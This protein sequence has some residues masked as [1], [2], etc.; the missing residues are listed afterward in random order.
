MNDATP[1]DTISGRSAGPILAAIMVGSVLL[2]LPAFHWLTGAGDSPDFSFHPDVGQFITGAQDIKAPNPV[3]YPE[4]LVTH[5][6]V[7]HKLLAPLTGAGYMQI[8]HG[9]T[10][11]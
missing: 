3:G 5:L 7:L 10:I 1:R 8:L 11:F 6:Y 4:G 9:I 2:R